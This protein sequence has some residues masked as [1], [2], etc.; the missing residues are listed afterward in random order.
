M[1]DID[2]N[3]E[4]GNT[5]PVKLCGEAHG[6][7]ADIAYLTADLILH[8]RRTIWTDRAEDWLGEKVP[9]VLRDSFIHD[10]SKITAR[11]V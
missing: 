6:I 2:P 1:A 10:L 8:G 3:A 7:P 9:S 5:S 4:Y 11:A